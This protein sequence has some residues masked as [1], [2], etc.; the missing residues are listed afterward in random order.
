MKPGHSRKFY[1]P[2]AGPIKVTKRISELNYEIIDQKDKKQ[3]VH[4]NRL[5]IADNPVLWKPKAKQKS[6]K[7]LHRTQA[8]ETSEAEDSVWKPRSL[9]LACADYT[10]NNNKHENPPGQSPTHPIAGH[11]HF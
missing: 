1:R 8:E 7:K 2:W 6:E 10:A 3:V 9:P 11:A 5:E 4:V